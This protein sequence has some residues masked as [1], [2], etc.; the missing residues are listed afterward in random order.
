MKLFLH[1][2]KKV[3]KQK[4]KEE[5]VMEVEKVRAILK[6]NLH[7]DFWPNLN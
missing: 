1:L 3:E 4:Y 7:A 2:E 6:V 5:L